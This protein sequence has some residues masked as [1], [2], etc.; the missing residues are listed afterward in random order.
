MDP[1]PVLVGGGD[2]LGERVE[3]ARVQVAR[4][5]HDDG[6]PL[7]TAREGR[8]EGVGAQAALPVDRDD[9]GRAQTEVAQRQVDGVV[10]LGAD[11]HPDPRTPVEAPLGHIP[12]GPAQDGIPA[13]SQRR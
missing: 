9:V 13:R 10:A 1:G 3:G 5:E 7:A 4:L 11:Q 12:A 2:G 8:S 6:G